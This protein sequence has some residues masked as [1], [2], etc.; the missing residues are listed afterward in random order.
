MQVELAQRVIAVSPIVIASTLQPA[1][2]G[3]SKSSKSNIC[4]KPSGLASW[5]SHGGSP[6]RTFLLVRL[7]GTPIF[8]QKNVSKMEKNVSQGRHGEGGCVHGEVEY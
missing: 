5:T 4:G 2:I 8:L 7:A 1:R 3:Y 6:V